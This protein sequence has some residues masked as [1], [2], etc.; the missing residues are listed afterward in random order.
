MSTVTRLYNLLHTG[1]PGDVA[2]Y[3]QCCTP[4]MTVLELGC[5]SGRIALALQKQGCQVTGLDNDSD[6]LAEF[7]KTM[8][9][10]I[11]SAQSHLAD[12]RS[13]VLDRQFDRIIIPFN[14]LLCMLSLA[15][16][17]R[18]LQTA[19]AHLTPE[20]ELIFDVYHVPVD[21]EN[22]GMEDEFYI[23]TAVL[24]DDG[25]Q[26]EVYEK[27]LSNA[28]PQRFDTSYIYVTNAHTAL[29]KQIEHTIP[30]R[31]LYL[32][33]IEQCLTQAGLILTA[34]RSDFSFSASR[35]SISDDTGQII[36]HARRATGSK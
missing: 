12:M 14:G 17:T 31:C 16:V 22:D 3:Q 4:G 33:Q 36:V 2:Y 19:A 13:F 23:D 32:H 26:V 7:T 30:Q 24:N 21:F 10:A 1:N 27:T 25:T 29:E 34:M 8:Q 9:G 20:G 11:P 6:M 35:D 28:D 5:G 18:V 15:D